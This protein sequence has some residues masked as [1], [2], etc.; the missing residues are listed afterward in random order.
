[1]N[2]HLLPN[3]MLANETDVNIS[4]LFMHMSLFEAVMELE[5]RLQLLPHVSAL[6]S[7]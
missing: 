4:D 5:R 6:A 2:M 3:D 1:M 7:S